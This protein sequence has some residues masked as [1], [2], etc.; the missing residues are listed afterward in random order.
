[1]PLDKSDKIYLEKQ[2]A[3]F[4]TK[5]D[6]KSFATKDD[7]KSFA[8]KDYLDQRL[9]QQTKELKAYSDEQTETLAAIIQTSIVEPMEKRFED[10]EIKLDVRERVENLEKDVYLVKKSLL[11]D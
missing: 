7:L 9:D 10:L 8:T 4:A 11:I 2:F 1:M 3:K 6:L 5:D